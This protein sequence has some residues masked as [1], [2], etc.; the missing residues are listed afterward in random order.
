MDSHEPEKRVDDK[1]ALFSKTIHFNWL[2]LVLAHA[3][4]PFMSPHFKLTFGFTAIASWFTLGNIILRFFTSEAI[5]LWK[6][7]KP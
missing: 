6:K 7:P 3:V 5:S 1:S 2:S 4:W